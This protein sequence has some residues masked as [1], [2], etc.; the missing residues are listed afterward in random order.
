MTSRP[1]AR[2]EDDAARAARRREAPAKIVYACYRLV[3][4]CQLYD[5]ANK[6]V[7]QQLAPFV[8]AVAEFGGLFDVDTVRALF[9]RDMVFVNRR[10]M[11]APRETYAVALQLGALLERCGITELSIDRDVDRQ[12]AAALGRAVADGQR[13]PAAAE[14]LLEGQVPGIAARHVAG[15]DAESELDQADSP[16]A[17]VIKAYAASILIVQSFYRR[18]TEGAQAPAHEV[19]RVAQKLTALSEEH[20]ELLGVA[21]AAPFPDADPARRA[22]STAVIALQMTRQVSDDRAVL[23][24]LAL[25]AL[26]ADVGEI[27]LGD[28][29]DLGRLGPSTLC[30]LTNL[31]KLYAAAMRRNAIAYEVLTMPSSTETPYP[32]GTP[33]AVLSSILYLARRFNELRAPDGVRRPPSVAQVLA[34]LEDEARAEASQALHQ[35]LVSA[36]GFLPVGTFVELDTGEVAQVT[37]SPELALDFARPPVRILTDGKHKILTAPLDV[38]LA[39]PPAG[40]PPRIVCRA[41]PL[42]GGLP[43]G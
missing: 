7:T 12:A 24:S 27:R 18:L 23:T 4:A 9:T 21:A 10:I 1:P 35:L 5:D 3:K 19:K 14:P 34:Q 43:L 38:D 31:G 39:R 28:S 42:G 29:A 37:G 36:L 6:T 41:L 11:R 40:H 15:P 25:A 16:V 32:D 8:Q 33:P 22:V 30:V 2:H 13:N 20:P 17:R 26:L